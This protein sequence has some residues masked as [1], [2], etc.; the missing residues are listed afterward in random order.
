MKTKFLLLALVATFG[1]QPSTPLHAT[2]VD[3]AGNATPS[4]LYSVGVA[5]DG[6]QPQPAMKAKLDGLMQNLHIDEH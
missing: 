2:T 5:V 1:S 4:V 3:A 6:T